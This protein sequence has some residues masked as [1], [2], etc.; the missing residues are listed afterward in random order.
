MNSASCCRLF[1]S[2]R[3]FKTD[4]VTGVAISSVVPPLDST[5]RRVCES[6]FHLRPLFI[7]PGVK[8]GLQVLT[9]NPAE[10]GRRPRRQLCRGVRPARAGPAVVVDMGT[11]T[12]F[13]VVS[14]T[15]CLPGRR[16]RSRGLGISADA[17]FFRAARLTS[18]RD[19]EAVQDHRH[20]HHR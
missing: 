16:H 10:V 5:L 2:V 6:Y 12:T 1:F 3:G 4:V 7:E 17:L 15:G 18:R 8:T 13:D 20:Q 19:Q 11:A 9:D 14:K